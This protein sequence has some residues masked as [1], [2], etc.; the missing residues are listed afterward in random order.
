M[1]SIQLTRYEAEEGD[2]PYVCMRCADPAT[3]RKRRLFVSHPLWVYLLLPLGYLPYVIVAAVL[4]QRVR[5][6]THFCPRHKKHWLV[7][8]LIIWGAFLALLALLVITIAV[9][10][11][12][13]KP[14]SESADRALV[15]LLCIAWP[16]LAFCWLVSIPL[17][18]L[19]AIHPAEVTERRLTLKRVSPAFVEAVRNHRDARTAEEEVEEEEGRGNRPRPSETSQDVYD[20]ER[21]RQ[22]RS[23]P[24]SSEE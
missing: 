19:T 4:T 23:H 21:R 13:G 3:V 16:A 15:G 12:M 18:Q 5:C 22:A 17:I 9:I 1:A 24:E 20:P 2:L 7:R 10:S 8:G 11:L 6:Y 14:L